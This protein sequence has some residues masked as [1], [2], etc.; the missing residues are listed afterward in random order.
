V[1]LSDRF[2][3]QPTSDTWYVVMVRGVDTRA[4]W[5]LHG[6]RAHAWTNA[7]LVD[8]DGSGAYDDF[9]LKP[10][11]PLRA[12]PPQVRPAPSVPTAEALRRAIAE[13]FNH[14]HE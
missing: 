5:P 12:P 6:A 4:S 7:I 13:L 8:A 2:V 9:P 3:V 14:S 1:R 11:Q 10:G